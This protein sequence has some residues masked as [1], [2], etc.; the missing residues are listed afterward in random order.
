MQRTFEGTDLEYKEGQLYCCNQKKR[1]QSAKHE[2]VSRLVIKKWEMY[3]FSS[4]L[5]RYGHL[6]RRWENKHDKDHEN[7]EMVNRLEK[8]DIIFR[9]YKMVYIEFLS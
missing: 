6:L 9:G 4:V 8:C 1:G 3:F 5:W 7:R 2:S